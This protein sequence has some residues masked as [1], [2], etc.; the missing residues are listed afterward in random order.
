MKQGVHGQRGRAHDRRSVRSTLEK[1]LM[2]AC[3]RHPALWAL[4]IATA[5]LS[6]AAIRADTFSV[7]ASD[8]ATVRTLGPQPYVNGKDFFNIEGSD[9]LPNFASWGTA[10]FN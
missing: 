4:V 10:D 7:P 1:I 8:N 2:I 6:D 5:F 9:N 3:S